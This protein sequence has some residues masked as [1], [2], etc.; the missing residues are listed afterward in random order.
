MD[1]NSIGRP[2]ATSYEISVPEVT[3]METAGTTVFE[4]VS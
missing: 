4:L 3:G 2:K 1:A